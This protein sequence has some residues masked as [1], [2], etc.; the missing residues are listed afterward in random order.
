MKF[1]ITVCLLSLRFI[2]YAQSTSDFINQT[3][4]DSLV[5]TVREFSGED[6]CNVGGNSVQILNRV[7][8]SGN[9]L[10]ADY[11]FERLNNIG[12]QV[13]SD[14]YSTKGRNIIAKHI[15]SLYPD[16]M[17][18]ICAHY[19]AVAN[20][21]ADDNASGVGI[22][23]EA[24]RVLSNYQFKKT[25]VFALWDEE[26]SGLLGAK[27]YA[28][29]ANT[30]NDIYVS[31]LNID[32]AGYDAN[33][34]GV[35]DIDLN[36]S[37]GS[38]NMKDLLVSI[39]A[40]NNLNISPAIVQPGTPDSD[41]SAFW[42]YQYP[43][44]LLGESWSTSDQNPKYHSSQ[45]RISLFNLPYYHEVAKLAV[46]FIGESAVPLKSVSAG[47]LLKEELLA[48]INPHTNELIVEVSENSVLKLIDLNGREVI[49]KVIL[50]GKSVISL[51]KI[52]QGIYLAKT[53][54]VVLLG[55][56]ELKLFK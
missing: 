1:F 23:L 32:M 45:D 15:G 47:N 20:Y 49:S 22:V 53:Y 39:N 19:D 11:L 13:S 46:G 42:T 43:A 16:S 27:S 40:A 26:E 44:V 51:L 56:S 41:H 8:D 17:V 9:D 55:V 21:C 5:K 12:L 50:R 37:L 25:I 28:A 35:F 10:A 6:N 4:L 48:F 30:N 29:S 31:I 54:S 52:P 33:N 2:S 14:T 36:S 34:D 7:S 3:S 24:A 18:M 38:E